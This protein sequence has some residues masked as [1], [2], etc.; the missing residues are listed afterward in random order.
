MTQCFDSTLC[1]PS[2]PDLSR[3][4][5]LGGRASDQ[6]PIFML[7]G[8]VGSLN[9]VPA[10]GHSNCGSQSRGR[11]QFYANRRGSSVQVIFVTTGPPQISGCHDH[12]EQN[13]LQKVQAKLFLRPTVQAILYPFQHVCCCFDVSCSLRPSASNC[14]PFLTM[15]LRQ[16][17]G[18]HDPPGIAALMIYLRCP[19]AWSVR[20][21]HRAADRRA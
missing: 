3:R 12:R 5:H 14:W 13:C 20:A 1:D 7:T 17:R 18:D 6:M 4:R 9:F 2:M 19:A 16:H 15:S 21:A 11:E 10:R 8:I